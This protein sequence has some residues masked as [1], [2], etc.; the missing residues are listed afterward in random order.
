MI[1]GIGTMYDDIIA[2]G[3]VGSNVCRRLG[4]ELGVKDIFISFI[5][6]FFIQ[7]LR[8]EILDKFS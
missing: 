6:S 5:W 7:T 1:K 2:A 4:V 3:K 8:V